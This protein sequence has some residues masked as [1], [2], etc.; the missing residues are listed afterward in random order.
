MNLDSLKDTRGGG[1]AFFLHKSI[2]AT[3][4]ENSR[5]NAIGEVE[6]SIYA[7]FCPNKKFNALL[8]VVYRPP[9][10][11]PISP[12][13]KILHSF[14]TK[15]DNII[16]AGDFNAH[17]ETNCEFARELQDCSDALKLHIL[18]TGPT[19]HLNKT[20][21]WL[22]IIITDSDQKVL[23]FE[24]SS[25]PFIAHHDSIV[26]DY[27][28]KVSQI[29]PK[30]VTYRN[31]K[32][33]NF[34]LMNNDILTLV[35]SLIPD[36]TNNLK[37]P[38]ESITSFNSRI[39]S[40]LDKFA[41]L[42]TSKITKPPAPWLTN[43]I[44]EQMKERDSYYK[45]FKKTGLQ[46]FRDKYKISRKE[47]KIIIKNAK[48]A[49]FS[50][51]FQTADQATTW[52]TLTKLG[53]S[54]SKNNSSALPFFS[55]QDLI[56][57]FT[58]T[59]SK[60]PN[61]SLNS[62]EKLFITYP[63]DPN[64]PI[65]SFEVVSYDKVFK[66]LNQTLPKSKGPSSDGIQLR[67]LFEAF[68]LVALYLASLFQSITTSNNYPDIW[69]RAF[70][71]PLCKK[72]P[73][74]SVKDVRP[75]V[76]LPHL[77]K[78]FDKIIGPQII[79]FL[80]ANSLYSPFQSAYRSGHSCQ[81]A[82]LK[83][84]DDVR[85]AIEEG[86]VTILILFDFS[87]AFNSVDLNLLF[88]ILRQLNF[89]DNALRLLHSYLT[90]RVFCLEGAT[91]GTTTCGVG[92]G[93]GPG[94]NLFN[95][96]MNFA[97]TVLV[98]SKGLM[99]ADDFQIYAHSSVENLPTT[100]SKLN[101][102]IARFVRWSSEVGLSLNSNKTKFIIIGSNYNLR[103]IDSIDLPNLTVQ[104][105]VIPRSDKVRNL[106]VIISED[107][108]WN[109]HIN[110]VLSTT[111][112]IFFF[113]NNKCFNLPFH[114]RKTLVTSLL[115]P[116]FDYCCL[117][118]ASLTKYLDNK[119]AHSFRRAVRFVY[120]L[121]KCTDTDQFFKKLKWLPP[122][123][124]RKYFLGTQIYNILTSK[125]PTYLFEEFQP[126]FSTI[127]PNTRQNPPFNVPFAFSTCYDKSF[128]ISAMKLWNELP[129]LMRCSDSLPSFK[130]KLQKH[131]KQ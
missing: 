23:R 16:I 96:I 5:V 22:D 67:H 114:I 122:D 102:D 60:H 126:F 76:N 24:K 25:A 89:S 26:V 93:A 100:V 39:T 91:P 12:L 21:S 113:L 127:H 55:S 20:D 7:L 129:L 128:S 103:K 118:Y 83:L 85:V 123:S 50:E 51:I 78:V 77:A 90:N 121:H 40:I 52:R 104:D 59:Y 86:K 87:L 94:G 35:N 99:F 72:T 106:G 112:K 42:K 65:F 45:I 8:C 64:R 80:E 95:L 41:P 131:L 38:I 33:C 119:I 62:L 57:Y 117:V 109:D 9:N 47:I 75:I 2:R 29:V 125:R 124:R 54:K 49:H 69:K 79:N 31:F 37:T 110:S 14:K 66:A 46:L 56:D 19:Y 107:L 53:Y 1:V 10:G 105:I 17:L 13:F 73:P 44:K 61:I 28:V 108:T 58:S 98:H 70:I 63:L 15:Y 27:D 88:T 4:I 11:L 34:N 130:S 92:Q 84:L 68:P 116:H 82:L 81:T 97:M 71:V 43:E 48:T 115:F 18:Q 101:G 6:Y 32:N 111:N 74:G 120:R 3:K 36:L 30:T